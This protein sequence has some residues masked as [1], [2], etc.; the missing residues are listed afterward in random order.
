MFSDNL[1][2][3][4][5]AW[6]L[7]THNAYIA[8]KA[9]DGRYTRLD[10]TGGQCAISRNNRKTAEWRVALKTVLSIHH[11][12]IQYRTERED[13]GMRV[14]LMNFLTLTMQGK[15]FVILTINLYFL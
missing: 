4:K 15:L 8:N 2:L 1:A 12:F 13:W 3:R 5:P 6:Q 14:F 7:S 11:V 10:A 9:V